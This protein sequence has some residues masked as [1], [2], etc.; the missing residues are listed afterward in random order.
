VVLFCYYSAIIIREISDPLGGEC[1]DGY[2]RFKVFRAVMILMMFIWAM[3]PCGLIGR[4]RRFGEA[5][6][7]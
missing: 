6:S 1:V 3:S 4:S 2:L 7:L 5:C